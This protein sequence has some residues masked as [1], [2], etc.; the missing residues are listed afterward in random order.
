[1]LSSADLTTMSLDR[2]HRVVD[3]PDPPS[4][5]GH[6]ELGRL[7]G[8]GG[9]GVV[10]EARDV[11]LERRVALKLVRTDMRH[12]PESRAR[13]LQEAR[14]LARLDHPNVIKV[15]ETGISGDH[16]FLAM[17][18]ATGGTLRDWMRQPRDWRTIVDTFLAVGRGLARV[19]ELGLVHRDVNPSNVFLDA[20]GTPKL[21]DFGLVRGA[22]EP[23]AGAIGTNSVLGHRLTAADSVL[24][25]PAYMAPEQRAKHRVDA[26]A[27]QYAFCVSL[28]EALVGDVPLD[29]KVSSAVPRALRAALTR[30]LAPAPAWRFPTM[31]HLGTAL[32]DAQRS[33]SW[34]SIFGVAA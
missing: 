28:H 22:T 29:G 19:H 10:F 18:L 31:A 21:G 6:F 16:L 5:L 34:L 20:R 12:A 1:M 4:L 27:D 30:G 26:R 2:V 15:F 32:A 24:G 23:S 33:R 7:L 13:L 3:Q 11:L 17:E 9:M 25:T 14:A 8:A